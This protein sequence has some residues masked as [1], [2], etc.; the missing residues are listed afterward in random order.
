M[1]TSPTHRM[2]L[3]IQNDLE[4]IESLVGALRQCGRRITAFAV[5]TN[6]EAHLASVTVYSDDALDDVQTL[7]R[8]LEG[9]NGVVKSQVSWEGARR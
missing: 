8:S 5:S 9:A 7:H 1:D 3:L 6:A 4:V 2:S